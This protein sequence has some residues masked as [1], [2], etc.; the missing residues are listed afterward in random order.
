MGWF[1]DPDRVRSRRVGKV[2]K[3]SAKTLLEDGLYGE[4]KLFGLPL[5]ERQFM[6]HPER[7]WRAD[8]AWPDRK[9]MIEVQGGIFMR[10]GGGHNRGAGIEG[11]HEKHNEAVRLGWYVFH[12][13][14]RALYIPSRASQ[15]SRALS[16]LYPILTVKI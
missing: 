8:F 13:G 3:P 11:D 6:F 2:K 7:K 9:I 1:M 5:P 12:F 15:A 14:P 10:G 16:F 4:F